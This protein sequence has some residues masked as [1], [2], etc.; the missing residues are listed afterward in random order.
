[1]NIIDLN[2]DD[3]EIIRQVAKILVP[4]FKAHWPSAWPDVESA[5][6]EVGKSFAEDRISRVALAENGRD[7]VT[8]LERLVGELGGTTIYLGKDDEDN[9]TSHSDKDLYPNEFEHLSN[10]E[11]LGG[12]PFSF[13]QKIGFSIVGVIPD[14]NGPGKP[15][16]IMAK[17]VTR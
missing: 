2:P 9:M 15:D 13:Y 10:I 5:L 16:I 17:R 3:H 12:H 11:N 7:L 8:D 4:T 1:M 14:A 6:Q